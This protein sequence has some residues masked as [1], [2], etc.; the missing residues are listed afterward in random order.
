MKRSLFLA[1]GAVG[2]LVSAG[3]SY[4]QPTNT[5]TPA[6]TPTPTPTSNRTADL[7]LTK[8]ASPNPVRVGEELTYTLTARNN[9]PSLVLEVNLSDSLPADVTFVSASFPP[10][11]CF[12]S[13]GTVT[14]GLGQA[15]GTGSSR[16]AIIVVRPTKAGRITNSA[17]VHSNAFDP[18]PS[19]NTATVT[20]DVVFSAFLHGSGVV[21]NPPA[22]FLDGTAPTAATAKYKDSAAVRSGLTNPWV[23]IGAWPAQPGL[24]A[25][26]LDALGDL[27]LWLGLKNSDDEG[28]QFNVRAEVWKNGLE[29][30]ASGE[31]AC[32]VGVTRN[33]DKAREVTVPFDLF[34]PV[35]LDGSTDALSLKVFDRIGTKCSGPTHSGAAGVRLYFDGLRRP[36]GLG[37]PGLSAAG[38][39]FA[40]GGRESQNRGQA[41]GD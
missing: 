14:C 41:P 10:G 2:A 12:H 24:F 32:V 13:G 9:G 26:T 40:N 20:T 17:E 8:A 25:G 34:P 35:N 6:R 11:T 31:T 7:S 21:S 33:P 1:L 19:N 22:L 27:R 5:P 3:V 28:T 15:L 36:S 37:T 30:V 16:Q 4:G 18:F 29:L 38:I 39:R 23:E